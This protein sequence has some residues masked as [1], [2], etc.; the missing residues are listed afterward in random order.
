MYQKS[1]NF[2]IIIPSPFDVVL[3]V[4]GLG[5]FQ[6]ACFDVVEVFHY[7]EVDL[8]SFLGEDLDSFLGSFLDGDLDSFLD[9]DQT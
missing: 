2:R 5:A 8:G 9:V 6:V 1:I 3:L 4:Q 7:L